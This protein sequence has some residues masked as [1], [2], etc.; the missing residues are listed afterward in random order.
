MYVIVYRIPNTV[1]A[2]R[3][4]LDND[5]HA[6]TWYV[7]ACE[8]VRIEGGIYAMLLEFDSNG[9]MTLLSDYEV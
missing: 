7:N 1:R 8:R 4:Q 2:K 9:N 6:F 3:Q 5:A